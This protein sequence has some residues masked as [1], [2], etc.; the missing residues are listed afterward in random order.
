MPPRPK[1]L[2]PKQVAWIDA[3]ARGESYRDAAQTAGVAY[4]TT[5]AWRRNPGVRAELE[6]IADDR[7]AYARDSGRLVLPQAIQVLIEIMEDPEANNRDRIAACREL[8]DRLGMPKTTE[9]RTV[10]RTER[11][12]DDVL[13]DARNAIGALRVVQGGKG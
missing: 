2:T 10:E 8:L 13:A 11:T 1:P 6:R 5:H 3:V 7:I 12:A 4:G 9:V